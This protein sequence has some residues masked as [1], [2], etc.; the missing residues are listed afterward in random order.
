MSKSFSSLPTV[1]Q[2]NAQKLLQQLHAFD[3]E[4]FLFKSISLETNLSPLVAKRI[5]EEIANIAEGSGFGKVTIFIQDNKI[6]NIEGERKYK[7]DEA[8]DL[9]QGL[10]ITSEFLSVTETVE[11]KKND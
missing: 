7:L 6:S 3:P 11:E 2:I 9:A 5:Y 1:E 4:L 10:V 8:V